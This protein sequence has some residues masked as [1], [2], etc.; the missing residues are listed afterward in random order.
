MAPNPLFYGGG[1]AAIPLEMIDAEGEERKKM[2]DQLILQ[3]KRMG[4]AKDNC[5]LLVGSTKA[6]VLECV[7]RLKP[8]LLICGAH[9]KH[10]LALLR[11]STADALFHN[12]P[13][14]ILAVHLKS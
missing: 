9:D 10:G 2:E 13:C 14:D 7:V 3:G 1:E 8:N 5:W 6:E 12:M 4:I 11:A